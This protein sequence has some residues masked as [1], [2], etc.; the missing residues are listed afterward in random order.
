MITET[1]VIEGS[2]YSVLSYGEYEEEWTISY[3]KVMNNRGGMEYE[4]SQQ[5]KLLMPIE[6]LPCFL[7]NTS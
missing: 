1:G 3:S 5:W 7:S 4:L 6:I 2:I